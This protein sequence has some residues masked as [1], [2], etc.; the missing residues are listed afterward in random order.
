MGFTATKIPGLVVFEP[1][2]FH[3][4][5]GFF[6][7][8]YKL[9]WYA[10]QG[11]AVDFIQDNHARSTGKGVL[12]GLHFQSPP[13]SQAKLVRVTRGAVLDVA[14]DLRRGSP[15]YGE[16]FAIELSEENFKQLFVP[17]GFAHGYL[18]LTDDVEFLYKVDNY[19]DRE[20]DGGL[21]WSDPELGIDWGVEVPV[22][23]DKDKTLP[24]LKDFKSPFVFESPAS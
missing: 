6:L 15:A 10:K 5:R 7:E 24:R 23:S 20:R 21:L 9:D 1:R 22:L 8:S 12:R 11:I 19:Y 2:V 4:G 18:T 14:V 3:D 13:S 17:R 16:H